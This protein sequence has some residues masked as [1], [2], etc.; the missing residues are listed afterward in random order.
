MKIRIALLLLSFSTPVAA[1]DFE[2]GVRHV[3]VLFSES[4]G[5]DL[6]VSR[7]WAVS[8][9]IYWSKRW[10]LHTEASFINPAVFSQQPSGDEVDLDTLNI[11]TYAATIRWNR[12]SR[13]SSFAGAGAAW[14]VPGAL[15]D[16]FGEA[17]EINLENQLTFIVEGG[18]RW[19]VH[20]RV[21]VD[22]TASWMPLTSPLDVRRNEGQM[23]LPDEI[24]LNP[25]T[26]SG[27]VAWRF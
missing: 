6:P 24:E 11:D 12:G 25:L 9:E 16:R 8:S 22:A 1:A 20:P 26:L 23:V 13:W 10:S 27:G 18:L 5:I 15:D 17:L 2:A 21:T 7:G 14:V 3:V 4:E 19:R